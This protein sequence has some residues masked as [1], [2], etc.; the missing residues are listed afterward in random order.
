MSNACS[1]GSAPPHLTYDG[2]LPAWDGIQDIVPH[3]DTYV[4]VINDGGGQEAGCALG[5]VLNCGSC[6]DTCAGEDDRTQPVC[7]EN[8]CSIQCKEE[9]YDVNSGEADG[10][11]VQDDL[12]IH[13]TA[14]TAFDMGQV[15]D[16]DDAQTAT[17]ILPSDDRMHL[18]APTE[19]SNGRAD[20]FT[21]KITDE[22]FCIVNAD[23][24]V[25]FSSLPPASSYRAVATFECEDGTELAPDS[26]LTNGGETV[27]LSPST[28][29]TTVGDDTGYL[30][31]KISKETGP[32]SQA[33]YTLSIEP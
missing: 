23:V 27:T 15:E 1:S 32:H 12:P 21:L 8:Q 20:W 3:F 26:K 4:P 6:G 9:F 16:C 14:S 22:M 24:T 10:C 29:C 13:D 19:R 7:L 18:V 33:A 5:T 2:S 11:E 25:S 17:G 28:A 30:T 31:V